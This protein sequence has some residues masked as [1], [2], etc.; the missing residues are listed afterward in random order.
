M[1]TSNRIRIMIS[2]QCKAPFPLKDPK[3]PRLS[4]IRLELKQ[5]IEAVDVFGEKAFEVWI[6]EV[7]PPK[8]GRWDSWDTCLQAVKDCDILLVLCNGN[9][10]WAKAGGDI[11][12]CHAELSTGLSVAPGKV[13]LISL[14]NIP[15][16]NSPEGRRNKRFQEYVALQSQFRGG[17]VQTVA[18]LKQRVNEA[19][20]EAVIDLMQRGVREASRGKFH[21]GQALDWSRLD[22]AGRQREIVRVLRDALLSR[23]SASEAGGNL[24]LK[25]GGGEVLFLANAIPAAL[26]VGAAKEMVGQP[27]LKDH[28]LAP[29]LTGK[30]SGPVHVIGCHKGVTETQATRLLGFPDA[31][32]VGAPFGVYVADGI[33]QIQLAFLKDCRDEATTRHNVQRFLEWLEQTGE[34]THLTRRA[35]SRAKIVKAIAAELEPKP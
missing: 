16:D 11:G 26:S 23:P 1:A 3:A 6:N 10:G 29:A 25:L 28:R 2:S 15:C 24:F 18:E 8:G 20:H 19:L 34:A 13:W 22:F 12:I 4:E 9:A 17:E 30:R 7:V 33:Q 5:A 21:S 27:F 14:G 32:V 35:V 31:E